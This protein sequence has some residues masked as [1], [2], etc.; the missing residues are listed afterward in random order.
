MFFDWSFHPLG[1]REVISEEFIFVVVVVF[2]MYSSIFFRKFQNL[3]TKQRCIEKWLSR[4]PK[5]HMGS[6]N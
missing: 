3:A 2:C 5:S 4:S 1:Q 6:K